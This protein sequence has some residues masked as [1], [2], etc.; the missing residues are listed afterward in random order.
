LRTKS[1][2]LL[3]YVAPVRVVDRP[4]QAAIAL[5]VSDF[6]KEAEQPHH[7]GDES[8]ECPDEK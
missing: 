6:R 7:N 2:N 3:K 5:V 4:I 1:P 8:D